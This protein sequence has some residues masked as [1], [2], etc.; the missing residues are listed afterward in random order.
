MRAIAVIPPLPLTQTG[1]GGEPR[2]QAGGTTYGYPRLEIP[3]RIKPQVSKREGGRGE[4]G[5]SREG[6]KERQIQRYKYRGIPD[7]FDIRSEGRARAI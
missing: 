1:T 7:M 2:D 6:K 3:R 5:G 4:G